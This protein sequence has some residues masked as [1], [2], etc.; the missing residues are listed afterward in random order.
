MKDNAE[1]LRSVE[2]YYSERIRFF[3]ASAAGVD[4][5]GEA[6]QELRFQQLCKVLD[7]RATIS[8]GDLGCGYGAMLGFMK[9][10]GFDVSYTGIDVSADMVRTAIELWPD[11]PRARFEVGN[12]IPL[13]MDYCV[14][15]GIFNVRGEVPDSAW[16]EYFYDTI[17]HLSEVSEKGFAF[18][19]L[20]VF[21]DQDRM[22][23]RLYY[24]DPCEV[25]RF[26]KA[27]CA[28]NVALL[29]DYGLYEFTILVRK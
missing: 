2:I 9:N 6:S 13:P 22:Q 8:V 17:M 24:A 3:G 18:N 21:S 4:W 7:E 1:I 29:H 25:F 26:C 15:S 27:N 12:K 16:T 10:A 11:D 5:N 28:R 20:T 23:A 14:A 19:C